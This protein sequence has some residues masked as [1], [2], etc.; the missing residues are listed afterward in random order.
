MQAPGWRHQRRLSHQPTPRQQAAA[1]RLVQQEVRS[2]EVSHTH[3]LWH[4]DFHEGSRAIGTDKG[5]WLKPQLLGIMDDY[6]RLICHCQW[7][8][9]EQAQT[10]VHGLSQAIQ[11]RGLPRALMSDNGAAMVAEEVRQGLQRLGVI[12]EY[13]LPSLSI[14]QAGSVLGHRGRPLDGD[15]G[16]ER[17]TLGQLNQA[18]QAWVE[19]EYHRR[20]HSELGMTPLERFLQG[21]SVTRTSPGSDRLRQCFRQQVS[22]RQRH[23]DGTLTVAGVRFGLPSRYRQL[24]RPVVRYARWDLS[25]IDRVDPATEAVLCSLYPLDKQAHSSA[26]RRRIEAEHQQPLP[27]PAC[28]VAPLLQQLLAEYAATG[29]P[30]AYLPLEDHS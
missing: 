18:T 2:F 27:Q 21:P 24:D 13:T 1:E 12:Q 20:I 25:H 14:C 17:L 8:L 29:L 11:K 4:L 6:S 19:Q 3:S 10:L 30:P 28:G 26:H 23:S 7:Y 5:Q 22:R 15:E 16:V 9:A